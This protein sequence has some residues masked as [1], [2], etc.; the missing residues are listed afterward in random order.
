MP[1]RGKR[2][3]TLNGRKPKLHFTE[4]PVQIENNPVS[5]VLGADNPVT[6]KSIPLE[7][8]SNISWISPNFKEIRSKFH[9][10]GC[11]RNLRLRKTSCTTTQRHRTSKTRSGHQCSDQVN[12]TTGRRTQ[13]NRCKYK[14]LIFLQDSNEEELESEL[15]S[16]SVHNSPEA[17]K[18]LLQGSENFQDNNANFH[19]PVFSKK[20]TSAISNDFN[21]TI[22]DCGTEHLPCLCQSPETKNRHSWAQKQC[23]TLCPVHQPLNNSRCIIKTSSIKNHQCSGILNSF[24]Q[25]LNGSDSGTSVS[26]GNENLRRSRRLRE[27][28][29]EAIKLIQCPSPKGSGGNVKVLVEDTP[30]SEYHI[31]LKRRQLRKLVMPL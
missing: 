7:D 24:S 4:S 21:A 20:Q 28:Y 29:L 30:E 18:T 27:K 26:P 12:N 9:L 8:C 15:H 16:I 31:R 14:P 23:A 1:R 2:K 10:G 17:E 6:A 11:R 19:T 3:S 22:Q 13:N 25:K 5:P